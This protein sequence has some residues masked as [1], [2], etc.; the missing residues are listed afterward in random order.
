MAANPVPVI[1]DVATR[2]P[3][4]SENKTNEREKRKKREITVA[5]AMR[6]V[7][8]EGAT[9]AQRTTVD[10]TISVRAAGVAGAVRWRATILVR[11]PKWR[12]AFARIIRDTERER[13]QVLP[14]NSFMADQPFCGGSGDI[15][16][17]GYL[18]VKRPPRRRFDV[19]RVSA[20]FNELFRAHEK[21][22]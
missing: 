16:K 10:G 14:Q 11:C 8:A 22:E 12:G 1:S 3:Y 6:L 5:L 13:S 4:R 18:Y 15:V 2:W 7:P 20:G 21:T 9:P 19:L 17:Q